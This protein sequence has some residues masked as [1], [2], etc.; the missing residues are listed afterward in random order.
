MSRTVMEHR[1]VAMMS[2][3]GRLQPDRRGMP[4]YAVGGGAPSCIWGELVAQYDQRYD[5]DYWRDLSRSYRGIVQFFANTHVWFSAHFNAAATYA[6]R[7]QDAGMRWGDVARLF[8]DEYTGVTTTST[9]EQ[10]RRIVEIMGPRAYSAY[11]IPPV[12]KYT[13]TAQAMALEAMSTTAK[14]M[15]AQVIETKKQMEAMSAQLT[16]IAVDVEISE[17]LAKANEM[18][19]A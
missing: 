3:L 15:M 4:V 2:E 10:H 13:Y 1:L 8:E 11:L 18:V 12:A 17:L 9:Q 16:D 14:S 5:T 6:Q 19:D 7:A